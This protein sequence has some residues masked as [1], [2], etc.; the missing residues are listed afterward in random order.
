MSI[1]NKEDYEEPRCLLNMDRSEERPLYSVPIGRIVE[2]LDE[3]LSRDDWDGA[4]RHLLYWLAEAQAG[5]DRRGELS[6]RNELMGHYRKTGREKEARESMR[7][8]LR[9]LDGLGMTE[10]I[11]AG[12]TWVNAATVCKTFGHADEAMPY[13]EKALALYERELPDNDWRLGGLYNNMA[14]ALADLGRYDEAEAYYQ[15][16]LSTMGK[17]PGSELE[18]AVTWMNLADLTHLRDE[19]AD[20]TGMLEKAEALLQTESLPRDGYY[21]YVCVTCAPGFDYYGWFMT[22]KELREAAEKIY[23]GT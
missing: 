15:K 9:L 10:N 17:I 1:L 22:A 16:A 19:E 21:A 2:K 5:G 13:F 8:A 3:Y 14:L 11:I 6:L 7:E 23:A 4:G 20:V 12:T 18:Q